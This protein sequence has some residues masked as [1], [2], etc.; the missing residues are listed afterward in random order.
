MPTPREQFEALKDLYDQIDKQTEIL[1][2][3]NSGVS[4][5]RLIGERVTIDTRLLPE[6]DPIKVLANQFVANVI[7]ATQQKIND[8]EAE[9][10]PPL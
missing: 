1:T 2:Q 10:N 8:L 6:D 5:V 7:A 4:S 9:A 3:L